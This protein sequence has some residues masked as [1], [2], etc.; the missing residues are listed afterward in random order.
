MDQLITLVA[1]TAEEVKHGVYYSVQHTY[2][3]TADES[4]Q[5]VNDEVQLDGIFAHGEN[6][7]TC[8][9]Q[10][11]EIL[12]EQADKAHCHCDEGRFLIADFY[13]H[14][15]GRDSHKQIGQEVHHITHHTQGI[16]TGIFIF[17]DSTKRSSQI[18]HERDHRKQKEHRNDCD[19]ITV[20]F[21]VVSWFFFSFKSV[22]KEFI[23]YL[24]FQIYRWL[25]A[26]IRLQAGEWLKENAACWGCRGSIEL[27]NI[28]RFWQ[29]MLLHELLQTH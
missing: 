3:E 25:F 7:D 5:Q 19:E 29:G 17:P 26:D 24:R 18:G 20:L 9:K 8:T 1:T 10:A 13:K 11:G 28:P 23:I 22:Y 15:A 21:F 27:R 2:T 16:G 12:D 4:S 6:S 14:V